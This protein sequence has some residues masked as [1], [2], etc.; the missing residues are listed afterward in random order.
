MKTKLSIG[1]LMAGLALSFSGFA[2]SIS[3]TLHD[4]SGA[5]WNTATINKL[6][7]VC[8]IP[9][10]AYAIVNAPLWSHAQ[11][12]GP[13]TMYSSAQSST[14]QAT[15]DAAPSGNSIM[16]LSCHDGTVALDNFKPVNTSTTFM[17]AGPNLLSTTLT[18]DHP[19]S[20]TYNTALSTADGGLYD[21]ATQAAP[22][23]Y[24][25][26]TIQARMLYNDRVQCA[27]CHNPHNNTNG[28]FLKMSTPNSEL[29]LA[30]HIK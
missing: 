20:M 17:P 2:Q 4:M 18:N 22:A 21:P 1:A 14:Y 30:C 19:I 13:Y 12:A 28:K 23:A 11:G 25:A 7:G 6:C 16:C 24:G 10:D 8:H 29:C 9:H 26:G 15:N 5:A 27:T 3:G